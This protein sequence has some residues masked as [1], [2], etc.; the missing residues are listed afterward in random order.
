M[1]V[2]LTSQTSLCSKGIVVRTLVVTFLLSS[3]IPAEAASVEYKIHYPDNEIK[4]F[5]FSKVA[6][7]IQFEN[8]PSCTFQE[9]STD[10]ASSVGLGGFIACDG[11]SGSVLGT[12]IVCINPALQGFTS[13]EQRKVVASLQSRQ[14]TVQK[15]DLKKKTALLWKIVANCIY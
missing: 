5:E 3:A 7:K 12:T 1:L 11:D 15:Y 10:T 14:L 2:F 13:S 9:M 6:K 8:G 4:T